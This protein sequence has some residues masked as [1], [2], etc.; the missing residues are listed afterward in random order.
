MRPRETSLLLLSNYQLANAYLSQGRLR[1]VFSKSS[2][3]VVPPFW[4]TAVT[5]LTFVVTGTYQLNFLIN[6]GK[7]DAR[8][9]FIRACCDSSDQRAKKFVSLILSTCK[10]LACTYPRR[11]LFG[12]HGGNSHLPC[13]AVGYRAGVTERQPTV[14]PTPCCSPQ[15]ERASECY[16][17]S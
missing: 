17:H 6:E 14:A 16:Q 10:Y 4:T 11:I 5:S 1:V 7:T 15:I 3:F 13:D 8:I 9:F 12:G 2:R